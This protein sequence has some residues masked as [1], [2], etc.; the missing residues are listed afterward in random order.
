MADMQRWYLT[1]PA[2]AIVGALASW[3]LGPAWFPVG[4]IGAMLPVWAYRSR[5]SRT[6]EHFA[7]QMAYE[8]QDTVQTWFGVMTG[9]LLV[10]L[11]LA[12]TAFAGF[13]EMLGVLGNQAAMSPLPIAYWATSAVSL[14]GMSTD[15]LSAK[16]VGG[17]ALIAFALAYMV[18][19]G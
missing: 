3:A 10:L 18:K 13:G 8:V 2:A 16:V 5:G 15:D 7:A 6:A 12:Q 17:F 11:L 1:A 4:A 19:E 9:I 14:V